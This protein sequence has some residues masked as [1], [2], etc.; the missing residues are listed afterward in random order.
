MRRKSVKKKKKGRVKVGQETNE[1][2]GVDM[3]ITN[4]EGETVLQTAM[5][6]ATIDD[7]IPQI[8]EIIKM[9]NDVRRWRGALEVT[10]SGTNPQQYS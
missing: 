6:E 8:H 3:S 4:N 10:K 1:A 7:S 2:S 5:K 9:L